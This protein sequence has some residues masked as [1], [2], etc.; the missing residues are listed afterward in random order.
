MVLHIIIFLDIL[1]DSYDTFISI[2]TKT[3]FRQ[4]GQV[5]GAVDQACFAVKPIQ[6]PEKKGLAQK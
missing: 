1:K 3:I 4:G 2:L 5:P 6:Q